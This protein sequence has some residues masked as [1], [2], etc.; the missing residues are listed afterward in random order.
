M[1]LNYVYRN[2]IPKSHLLNIRHRGSNISTITLYQFYNYSQY[3]GDSYDDTFKNIYT[4][5]IC[6]ST[7]C[8]L[9]HTNLIEGP[10]VEISQI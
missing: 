9:K 5:K 2:I 8:I 1:H 7:Q 6:D 4:N 3:P 10:H